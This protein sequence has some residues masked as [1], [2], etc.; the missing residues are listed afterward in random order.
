[1]HTYSE[2]S[3]WEEELRRLNDRGLGVCGKKLQE[4]KG[5]EMTNKTDVTYCWVAFQNIACNMDIS[6][7]RLGILHIWIQWTVQPYLVGFGFCIFH[8]TLIFHQHTIL[9]DCAFTFSP[10]DGTQ[11]C[12][13]HCLFAILIYTKSIFWKNP[14]NILIESWQYFY[15]I[16]T[17]L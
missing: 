4:E 14:D 2:S 15:G 13:C 7:D 9:T 11:W 10:S 1:M 5:R 17:I 16:L 3:S 12:W 6:C 8:L